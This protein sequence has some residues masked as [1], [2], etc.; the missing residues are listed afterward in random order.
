MKFRNPETGEVLYISDAVDKYCEGRWCGV[1]CNLY[2]ACGHTDKICEDWAENHPH[3]AAHLMG[4]E[5]VE[6]EPEKTCDNCVYYKGIKVCGFTEEPVGN[7]DQ[8]K[9]ANMNAIE[10]QVRE[11]VATELAAANRKHPPFHSQHEG[12]AVIWEETEEVKE[13]LNFVVDYLKTAW[14]YIRED[15]DAK[16][17]ITGP[18]QNAAI[19]LACE[20]IQVAAMCEKFKEV[21]CD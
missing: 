9:E 11:L 2:Y 15:K 8:L 17:I 7:S 10:A 1:T 19:L 18:I 4:Y 5:V 21:Y 14:R 20:A 3:E 16:N 6:E 12:I 13:Y